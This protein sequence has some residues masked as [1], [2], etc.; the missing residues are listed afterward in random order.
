MEKKRVPYI[1]H[2][3]ISAG[4]SI[5]FMSAANAAKTRQAYSVTYSVKLPQK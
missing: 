1:S 5:P 4:G 3:V 2:I